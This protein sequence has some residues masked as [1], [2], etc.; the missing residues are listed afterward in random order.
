MD[1]SRLVL[2][3]LVSRDCLPSFGL[4]SDAPD[5]LVSCDSLCSFVLSSDPVASFGFGLSLLSSGLVFE[6]A[7]GFFSEIDSLELDALIDSLLSSDIDDFELLPPPT[8]FFSEAES[9]PLPPDDDVLSDPL[10]AG[11]LLSSGLGFVELPAAAAFGF[12]DVAESL[13]LPLLDVLPDSLLEPAAGGFLLSWSFPPPPP[14]LL[15]SFL[16]L[17]L[18][19]PFGSGFLLDS[20]GLPPSFGF[21]SLLLSSVLTVLE[22]FELLFESE[23]DGFFGSGFLSLALDLESEELDGFFWSDDFLSLA[24]VA[25]VFDSELDGFF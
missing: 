11:F 7:A 3:L 18:L 6:L 17:L 5:L 20:D 13:P 8:G 4:S 2:D 24:L 9:L 19:P 14:L 10:S 12:S 21:V 1:F 25:L 16:T 22:A 15:S 23:L